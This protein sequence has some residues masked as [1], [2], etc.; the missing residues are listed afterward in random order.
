LRATV[1]DKKGRERIYDIDTT[2]TDM[3]VWSLPAF[4]RFL[5]PHYLRELGTDGVR[6]LRFDV[7]QGARALP[8]LHEPSTA[9]LSPPFTD[10]VLVSAKK[11]RRR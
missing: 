10:A 5:A 11:P 7:A 8:L 1:C 9:Q 6:K 3:L 4:D 2:K